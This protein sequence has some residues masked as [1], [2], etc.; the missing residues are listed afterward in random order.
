MSALRSVSH[1]SSHGNRLLQRTVCE[2]ADSER[3]TIPSKEG[4]RDVGGALADHEVNGDEA[5]E[6]DGPCRVAQA[7]L[8]GAKDLCDSRFA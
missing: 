4:E 5:L 6:D 1:Q 7:V 3:I 2:V 8:Q